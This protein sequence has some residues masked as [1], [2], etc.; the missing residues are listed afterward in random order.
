MLKDG[1]AAATAASSP[2]ALTANTASGNFI[3]GM[4]AA[5]STRVSTVG[6]M[7]ITIAQGKILDA[8]LET[9]VN[10][11]YP[12]P[13]RALIS[14]D[15]FS[16]K[17]T[18]VLIPKGSR[19]IGSLAGGYTPGNTRIMIQWTRIIMPSGND[20]NVSGFPAVGPSGMI[21]VEGIID[22]Q[23][24]ETLGSAALLSLINISTA[25]VIQDKFKIPESTSTT[26]ET[27]AGST[28]VQSTQTPVQQTAQE[29]FQKLSD[30]SNAWIKQNFAPT[31]YIVLDQGTRV[32]VFVNQDIRFPKNINNALQPVR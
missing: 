18:N 20:I 3:P 28:R 26:T 5:S 15:V 16:D 19:L 17:G 13:V 8:V 6:D 1:R 9:P 7:S 2:D 31:P 21:G 25:K 10:T 29:E 14:R 24:M 32:K 4:S 12:G 23:L 22:R 30:M 27:A 11:K